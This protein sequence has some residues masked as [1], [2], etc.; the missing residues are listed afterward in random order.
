MLESID[1]FKITPRYIRGTCVR[2]GVD[3]INYDVS[4][5]VNKVNIEEK[6]YELL[7]LGNVDL[8]SLISSNPAIRA[9]F[10]GLPNSL[11]YKSSA[12]AFSNVISSKIYEFLIDYMQYTLLDNVKL[13]DIENELYLP[14]FILETV[15]WIR[16]HSISTMHYNRH[17]LI[18]CRAE[19]PTENELIVSANLIRSATEVSDIVRL[20]DFLKLV[21]IESVNN[22]PEVGK[23][24]LK[25][26]VKANREKSSLVVL[27]TEEF[28]ESELYIWKILL[29]II[30]ITKDTLRDH[31]EITIVTDV[32]VPLRFTDLGTETRLSTDPNFGTY[33]TSTSIDVGEEEVTE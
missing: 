8:T 26:I 6:I 10:S 17:T 29:P 24:T 15:K 13:M 25:T 14:E 18:N 27:A 5:S 33:I 16:D 31:D 12:R 28:D 2:E 11:G 21:K 19:K 1:T 7:R 22:I 32:V 23:Y 20:L 4:Y 9:R 3:Q 30:T